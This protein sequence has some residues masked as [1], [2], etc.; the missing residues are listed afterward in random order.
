MDG[1]QRAAA[2]KIGVRV[3]ALDQ[4]GVCNAVWN[5]QEIDTEDGETLDLLVERAQDL[6]DDDSELDVFPDEATLRMS[7]VTVINALSRLRVCSH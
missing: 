1:K 3:R 7:L 6:I 4:C 5:R 2:L